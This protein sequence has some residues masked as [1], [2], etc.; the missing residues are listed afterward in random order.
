MSS[1]ELRR[2][3]REQL[4]GNWPLAIGVTLVCSILMSLSVSGAA[5][6]DANRAG[7]YIS[8]NLVN[9]LL[10]GALT[11]GLCRF[12]LNLATK[13]QQPRFEDLFAYFKVFLKTVLLNIIFSVVISVGLALFI[14][15]GIIAGLY[16][17]Q[18]FFILAED[19]SKSVTQC[20]TE[21]VHIMNGHKLELVYLYLSFIGW[22]ILIPF[23]CGIAA[24]WV[25]PY[26][27]LTE[28]N[29]HLNIR[30]YGDNVY[31]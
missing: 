19:S 15:P 14:V 6:H 28:A 3:S 7:A 22:F 2:K 16:F 24:L 23:T 10:G 21:S 8:M 9:L 13:I 31:I 25:M 11:T 29:F 17:S 5:S 12:M 18:C 26:L 4:T 30:S 27:R 20:L 1:E